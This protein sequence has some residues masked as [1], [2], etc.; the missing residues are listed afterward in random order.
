MRI[1][2]A[3]AACREP[4]ELARTIVDEIGKFLQFDH[5]YFTARAALA[6]NSRELDCVVHG[7]RAEF[8]VRYR[9]GISTQAKQRC[10]LTRERLRQCGAVREISMQNLSA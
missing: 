10:T 2:E 5:L 9:A 4:E 8:C 1:S 3:I 7:Y 6:E